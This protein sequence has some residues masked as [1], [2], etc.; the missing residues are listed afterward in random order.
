MQ[1][2][3]VGR[4]PRPSGAHCGVRIVGRTVVD[5]FRFTNA[6]WIRSPVPPT[7]SAV[8]ANDPCVSPLRVSGFVRWTRH[9]HPPLHIWEPNGSGTYA[10]ETTRWGLR[11]QGMLVDSFLSYARFASRWDHHLSIQSLNDLLHR[12]YFRN[13]MDHMGRLAK[14]LGLF[15]L[16]VTLTALSTK[17]C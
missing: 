1:Y 17:G 8:V 14:T 4:P 12:A 2:L 16:P 10:M 5:L 11:A 13:S 3:L 6:Q 7:L 9:T 15:I